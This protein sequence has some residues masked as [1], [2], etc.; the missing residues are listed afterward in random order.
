MQR[1]LGRLRGVMNSRN[2]RLCPASVVAVKTAGLAGG[3]NSAR[4]LAGSSQEL[5]VVL[6]LQCQPS[7]NHWDTMSKTEYSTASGLSQLP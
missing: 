5:L 1:Q 7:A 2:H 4:A 6:P 3:R